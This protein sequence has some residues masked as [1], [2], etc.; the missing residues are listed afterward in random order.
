MLNI[1]ADALLI[2]TRMGHVQDDKPQRH[3]LG[4]SPREFREIEGLRV[5]ETMRKQIR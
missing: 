5:S 3:E 2:V 4:R 1:F